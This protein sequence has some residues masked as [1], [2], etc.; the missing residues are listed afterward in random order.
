MKIDEDIVR[1]ATLGGALLGG[2]GGGSM[3][4]GR[5]LGELALKQGNPFIVSVDHMPGDASIVTV[6]AVGAPAAGDIHVTPMDYVKAVEVLIHNGVSVDGLITCENG[7]LATLN[8]WYQSA[9]LG[10]PVIDA[11]CNGRPQDGIRHRRKQGAGDRGRI[12]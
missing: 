5:R 12:R 4:E 7:G 8:G 11:P 6:S 1:Y 10:I 3:E 2:G 9:V